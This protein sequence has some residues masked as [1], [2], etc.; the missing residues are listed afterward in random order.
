MKRNLKVKSLPKATAVF[1]VE[2]SQSKEGT[3][4]LV[5]L[6]FHVKETISYPYQ[7]KVEVVTYSDL[8]YAALVG[9]QCALVLSRGQKQERTFTGIV[10]RAEIIGQSAG[11]ATVR[12]DIAAAVYALQ[13][14]K[15]SRVFENKSSAQIIE[16]VLSQGL[17]PFQR[18]VEV[19]LAKQYSP[20]E[21]CAQYEESDL[22]F[23]HRLMADEGMFYYFDQTGKTEKL[24]LVDSNDAC[25]EL[26]TKKVPEVKAVEPLPP[27]RLDTITLRVVE[28][29]SGEPIPGVKVKIKLLSGMEETMTT[30][31]EG[32]A[33]KQVEPATYRIFSSYAGKHSDQ[34]LEFVGEGESPIATDDSASSGSSP[35]KDKP[36][37]AQWPSELIIC[38][39]E[40][41]KVKIGET[42]LSLARDCAMTA[43][44]LAYYNW[45]TWEKDHIEMYMRTKVGCTKKNQQGKYCFDDSDDPGIIFC[46]QDWELNDVPRNKLHTLRVRKVD[47][48][49]ENS[50]LRENEPS[51]QFADTEQAGQAISKKS[52][53]EESQSEE[54]KSP[55]MAEKKTDQSADNRIPIK[56]ESISFEGSDGKARSLC[57]AL[58]QA[59]LQEIQRSSQVRFPKTDGG[60]QIEGGR[61]IM[62][63]SSFVLSGVIRL[64]I[65]L[66]DVETSELHLVVNKKSASIDPQSTAVEI[67]RG[68]ESIAQG[69]K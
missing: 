14:G 9:K 54:V 27:P 64:T 17:K 1:Q 22:G 5:V 40:K 15:R 26:T 69:K 19:K 34:Y 57:L 43:E 33:E 63:G 66:I 23:V 47:R 62:N 16:E 53:N 45:G 4:D 68:I 12:F 67:V 20:R 46:P 31:K 59:I 8:D 24:V 30:N 11:Q 44:E 61:W 51:Q 3:E 48:E 49:F 55:A 18:E 56:I 13:Y 35:S 21:C 28:N 50:A 6:E 2:P 42:L 7:G 38:K 39:V 60:E 10:F 32:L 29:E 41:H 52:P 36:N 58:D 25:P 65:K 37:T